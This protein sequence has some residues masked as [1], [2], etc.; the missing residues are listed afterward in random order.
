MSNQI[1]LKRWPLKW[2]GIASAVIAC[3]IFVL[4]VAAAE[5]FGPHML[6]DTGRSIPVQDPNGFMQGDLTVE[7]G[8]VIDDD[9][10]LYSGNV[11]VEEGGRITGDLFV[12]SGNIEIEEAAAVEGDVTNY[13]GNVTV[14]GHVGGDLT[15]MSGDIELE[16]TA[17]VDGDI[18]VMSGSIR[19][20]EGATV[21]G[22]VVQG[23]SFRFP[24]GFRPDAP[25]APDA[26]GPGMSFDTRSNGFGG[27]V[28][29][30]IGRLVAAALMTA[31]AMLLVGALFY[32]RPQLIADSRKQLHE[33]LALSAVVGGLANLTVLFLAGLLAVTLCLLPLAL[34]PML[35]LLVVNVVGWAVISQ[36]V[37][38]KIV[39]VAK[40]EVQPVLTLLV[41][42]FFL[43]GAL[44]LLWALGGCFQFVAWILIFAVA[45]VGS[46]AALLPWINR[47][48]GFGGTGDAGMDNGG[49]DVPPVPPIPPGP[50][51]A[52][53]TDVETDVAAPVDYVTAEEI[54]A[55]RG[56]SGA[57]AQ[58]G[59]AVG[60]DIDTDT[61]LGE[62]EV[63]EHDVA[64]P[65]D[66]MTAEE[67]NTTQESEEKP[68]RRSRARSG[69]TKPADVSPPAQGEDETVEQD[70]AAPVD[71]VTAQEV[72]TT[73]VVTEG[74]DFLQIKGIGPTYA[75]RLKEAGFTSYAHL[76]AATPE[77]L[78]E[79]IGWP[80]DR[81][82]RSEVIDQARVLASS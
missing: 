82:R 37:G 13:S 71:Y 11:E 28:L 12:F 39:S 18:S 63:V 15:A 68:A 16:S 25:V 32:A 33:Q 70:V 5:P 40:Q 1:S 10:M 46:G 78:A 74:D 72:N 55:S 6:P 53:S 54:N 69:E 22:N 51:S 52:Y 36:I 61:D 50:S 19:R 59:A 27:T 30:F 76:A 7:S 29:R 79:A 64:Q 43:I 42:A 2:L 67:I 17:S 23:P 56:T 14:A 66:Y 3:L 8:Q 81:V 48:R 45:S 62:R 80:V 31:L 26:P 20:D 4:P 58:R 73:D 49:G 41:G 9:V 35:L 77:A 24:R 34:I 44:A 57:S 75:R 21:S 60:S 47:R 38:E 65:L